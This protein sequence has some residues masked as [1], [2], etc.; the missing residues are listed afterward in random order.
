MLF[1]EYQETLQV[2]RLVIPASGYTDPVWTR[3]ADITGRIEPVNG[4]EQMLHQQSAG[5]LMEMLLL[6]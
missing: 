5:N 4:E 2:W 3:Q 1:D 6:L